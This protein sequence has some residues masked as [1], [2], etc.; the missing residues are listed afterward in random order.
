M[1]LDGEMPYCIRKDWFLGFRQY[2]PAALND[3]VA[4]YASVDE[5]YAR[6]FHAHLPIWMIGK[7]PAFKELEKKFGRE[8]RAQEEEEAALDAAPPRTIEVSERE[9]RTI[10]AQ[11]AEQEEREEDPL[12][13]G[14]LED[15]PF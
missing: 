4:T 7:S 3:I 15:H 2:G 12:L 9:Y 8:R 13:F 1:L 10:M 11:R 5:L 6:N 14:D